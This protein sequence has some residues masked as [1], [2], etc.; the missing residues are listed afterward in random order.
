MTP[1]PGIQD[2]SIEQEF[3]WFHR[4][5]ELA[6]EEFET[7][8]HIKEILSGL[9]GVELLDLGLPTGAL[10]KITGDP[11]GPVIAL[12]ADIDALPITEENGLPYASQMP[13]RMHACGHD[14]HTV[15]LI[16]AAELL[17]RRRQALP[18]T[19]V[20]LFQPAEEVAHWTPPWSA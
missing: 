18:G 14:F 5:P 13:G 1:S 10:A 4:H 19:V 3:E 17:A 7:S 12:R 2:L 20:L 9:A 15:A 6:F 16:G 8:K 11:H